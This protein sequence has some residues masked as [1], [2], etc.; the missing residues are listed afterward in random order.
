MKNL[1][2]AVAIALLHIMPTSAE[3]LRVASWNIANLASQPEQA[4]RGHARSAEVYA[5]INSIISSLDADC[6]SSNDL[7]LLGLWKIGVSGSVC[8]LI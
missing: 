8:V 7:R 4:L 1:A 5:H 3:N 2:A 6:P